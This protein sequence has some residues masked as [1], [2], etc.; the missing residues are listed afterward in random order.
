VFATDAFSSG[1]DDV[2]DESHHGTPDERAAAVVRG[3]ETA[4][5]ERRSFAEGIQV[6]L[7]YVSRL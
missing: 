3:F 2:N 4:F 5:H 6:G 7:N 1:D